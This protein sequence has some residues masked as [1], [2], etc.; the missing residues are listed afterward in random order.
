MSIYPVQYVCKASRRKKPETRRVSPQSTTSCRGLW[1]RSLDRCIR[2]QWVQGKVSVCKHL[3]TITTKA[4][5]CQAWQNVCPRCCP[6]CVCWYWVQHM[7]RENVKWEEIWDPSGSIMQFAMFREAV[8]EKDV[9]IPCQLIN[10]F[11]PNKSFAFL[12][13]S[14]L[15]VEILM[16][17]FRTSRAP[18]ACGG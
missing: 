8:E 4:L 2:L 16:M 18:P 15:G 14:R 1:P 11:A 17:V 6:S 13:P 10:P 5:Q 12:S 9:E 3:E 7:G